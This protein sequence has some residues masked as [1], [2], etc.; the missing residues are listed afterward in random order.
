MDKNLECDFNVSAD[1][2]FESHADL[3]STLSEGAVDALRKAIDSGK[4][5]KIKA[6][7]GEL[8]AFFAKLESTASTR[9]TP[10]AD[11][12]WESSTGA[13]E[14]PSAQPGV[15]GGSGEGNVV[16]VI[17]EE[18][19]EIFQSHDGMEKTEEMV[20]AGNLR[21]VNPSTSDRLWDIDLNLANTERTDIPEPEVYIREV[22]T[23]SEY[24][25]EFKIE[26]D[27]TRH[28]LVDEFISTIGDPEKPAFFLTVGQ[29]N[30]LFFRISLKNVSE[31][32]LTDIVL[33]KEIVPEFSNVEIPTPSVGEARQ[34]EGK[35]IWEIPELQPSGTGTI[36]LDV[37][38]TVMIDSVESRVRTGAVKVTYNVDSNLSGIEVDKFEA[39]TNNRYYL[40]EQELEEKPD[41][42]RCQFVFENTSGFILQLLSV[43]VYDPSNPDEKFVDFQPGEGEVPEL[44]SGAEWAS[45]EWE[46][47]TETGELSLAQK[48]RLTALADFSIASAGTLSVEDLELGV[49]QIEGVLTYDVD[50]LNSYTET[51]FGVTHEVSNT[52]GTPLN[53]VAVKDVIPEGFKPPAPDQIQIFINDEPVSVENLTPSPLTDEEIEELADNEYKER[54][55]EAGEDPEAQEALKQQI[56]DD[57]RQQAEEEANRPVISVDPEDQ[58]SSP[59]HTVLVDLPDLKRTDRE[60]FKPG[61]TLKVTYPLVADKPEAGANYMSDVLYSANT[62]PA[63]TPIEVVPE[64]GQIEIPV[65]HIRKKLLK[66]KEIRGTASTGQYSITIF[67][68]NLGEFPMEAI[69]VR[70]KVPDNFE[71]S[72]MSIEPEITD[73]EGEDILEWKFENVEPG[74]EKEITYTITG[75]G[76]YRASEAQFSM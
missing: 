15:S 73:L 60:A 12:S 68:K 29:E 25:Q 55:A 42:F 46:I 5:Q 70:D 48:C 31:Q 32:I 36:D 67:M 63:G 34:E 57:V 43:E 62:D 49:A 1:E 61:D 13:E 16:Q 3:V 44:S 74:E 7:R 4:R 54:A 53:E 22:E 19:R 39:F 14:T 6:E 20:V 65:E 10:S 64:A 40:D 38:A 72:D 30:P 51:E 11:S 27:G 8:E 23:E 52:G 18:N 69:V 28:V 45:E 26:D 58:E 37:K 33:E 76:E 75:S 66:G 41:T 35:V 50:M 71:Y 21:I 24:V 59:A 9:T 2:F 17:I 47:T 56:L